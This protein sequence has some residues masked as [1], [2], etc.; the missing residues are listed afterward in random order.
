VRCLTSGGAGT[1]AGSAAG[2][3]AADYRAAVAEWR[4]AG[5]YVETWRAR[6]DRMRDERFAVPLRSGIRGAAAA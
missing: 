2:S 5:T 1:R 3:G 4:I 6:L